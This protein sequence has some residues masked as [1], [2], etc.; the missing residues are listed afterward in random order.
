MDQP[1]HNAFVRAFVD[2][3]RAVPRAV[4]E[5]LEGLDGAA[6]AWAPGKDTNSI[7]VLVTHMVGS[8]IE[9][10]RTLAGVASDRV[11]SKEFETTDVDAVTL[12]SLVDRADATLAELAPKIDDARLAANHVRPG[13]LDKTPRPGAYVLMHSLAHAREHLGQIMLTRQLALERS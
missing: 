12:L 11:R 1:P 5:Q 9:A 10:V 6:L 3:Y 13:S 4:R 8:E 2:Q 7:A